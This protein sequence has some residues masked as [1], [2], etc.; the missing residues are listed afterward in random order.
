M[1]GAGV[2]AG[3]EGPRYREIIRTLLHDID[4]GRYAIGDRL[5]SEAE[6]CARFDVSRYTVREA[7]RQL[8]VLGRIARRQG[9]G[10]VVTPPP[11][12]THFVNSIDSIDGL[13]QYASTTQLNV[14]SVDKVIVQGEQAKRL[15]C[16]QNS[17]WMRVAALRYTDSLTRPICYTDLYLAPAFA[18]VISHIGREHTAVHAMIEKRHG[19]RIQKVLQDIEAAKADLN[20]ATRLGLE[21]GDPVLIVRRR[22]FDDLGNLLE[23]SMNAHPAEYFRYEMTLQRRSSSGAE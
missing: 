14:I 2:D 6:L 7:L 10:S 23:L 21:V 16:S 11:S 22:Y 8:K 20:L 4:A 19:V 13:L 15:R 12:A 9:A 18:D 1:S 3:T 17:E 5:P